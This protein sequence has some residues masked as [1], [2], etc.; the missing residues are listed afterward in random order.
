[1]ST[2]TKTLSAEHGGGTNTDF[3]QC[4]SG[5]ISHL[6]V[7]G[8]LPTLLESALLESAAQAKHLAQEALAFFRN[9]VHAHHAEEE[10]DLFPV[11]VAEATQGAERAHVQ[12]IVERLIQE[13]REVES[14]WTQ[15]APH[16]T[17]IANGESASLSASD[18]E[19]LVLDY[20]AHAAYEEAEFLPLCRAILGRTR[21][22]VSAAD[23]SH[24]MAYIPTAPAPL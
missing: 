9:S 18:V 15:L 14:S 22:H 1:M 16:L 20:A 23:L 21:K 5:I 8:G 24:H 17:K 11:V 6:M 4:H 3:S 7:F 2:T 12:A 13:H 10:R 19:T